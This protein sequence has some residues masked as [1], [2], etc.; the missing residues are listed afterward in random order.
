MCILIHQRYF[1]ISMLVCWYFGNFGNFGLI[2]TLDKKG[3]NGLVGSRGFIIDLE[4]N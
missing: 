1:E 3:F 4:M 2:F